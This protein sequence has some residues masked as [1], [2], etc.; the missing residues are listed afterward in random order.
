MRRSTVISALAFMFI[1]FAVVCYA[2]DSGMSGADLFKQHCAP[3]H[4]GGGNV[5]EPAYTLHKKDLKKHG[6]TKPQD[7]IAKM[8]NPGPGMTAFD[9]NTISDSDAEKIAE[10]VL[11]TF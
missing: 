10:Y 8:R 11:K 5:M 2:K 9:R 6:I 3:C 4:S 1:I 7:V